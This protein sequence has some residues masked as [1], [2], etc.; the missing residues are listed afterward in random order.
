M[1]YSIE[2][3]EVIREKSYPQ[4]LQDDI[5]NFKAKHAKLDVSKENSHDDV[6]IKFYQK[7][8]ELDL[9]L[10]HEVKS[11]HRVK[12]GGKE[13]LVYSD[14]LRAVDKEGNDVQEFFHVYGTQRHPVIAKARNKNGDTVWI[15]NGVKITHEI[16]FNAK[17]VEKII[18]LCHPD[19]RDAIA[20][21]YSEI[22][23]DSKDNYNKRE[24]F[25]IKSE[26]VFKTATNR[27]IKKIIE[28]KKQTIENL[29]EL[30]AP[31]LVPQVSKP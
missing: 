4:Y 23:V 21:S 11:I 9:E 15:P 31:V 8:K 30:Y 22:P 27:E 28:T 17:E 24:K 26:E 19:Y 12:R 14:N 20:F 13:K 18:K 2:Q 3:P 6:A 5:A 7:V 1:S 25:A 10:I 29:T 16:D